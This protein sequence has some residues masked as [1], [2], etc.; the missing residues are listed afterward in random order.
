MNLDK[1][2]TP[3]SKLEPDFEV[4]EIMKSLVSSNENTQEEKDF[5]AEKI[6]IKRVRKGVFLLKEGQFSKSSFHLFK[7]CVREFYLKDGEEKTVAFHTAGDS[8]SDDG[9]RS[10]RVPSG[11]SWECISEC[12]ISDFPFE[13]ENEMYQRFP[14]LESWCRMGME[15]QYSNY[16][17][18]VNNYLSSSPEERYEHLMK[19]KPRNLSI[20]SSLSHSELSRSKTRVFK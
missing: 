2:V 17:N 11:V 20:C 14:R 9:N 5:F 15:K 12:I 16:K 19:T 1:K 3:S 18:A 10:N 13:V 4:L 8:L 7:G 6:A